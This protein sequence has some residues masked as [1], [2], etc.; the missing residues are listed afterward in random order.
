VLRNSYVGEVNMATVDI[1]LDT[2]TAFAR[3]IQ[4][5]NNTFGPMRFSLISNGGAG[6]APNVG[7]VTVTGNTETGPLVSCDPPVYEAPNS[8]GKYRAGYTVTDNHFL[9][10]GNAM[11]FVR[12]EHVQ[13]ARNVVQFSNGQ[14]GTYAGVSLEDS[15]NVSVTNNSFHGAAQAVKLDGMSSA[16]TDSGNTR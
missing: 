14:C 10:Y 8:P 1:E 4:V 11:N 12:A 7:N 9:A 5:L 13:I 3:N 15:H 6:Y 2:D 16:V